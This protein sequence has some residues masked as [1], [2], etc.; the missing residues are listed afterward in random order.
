MVCPEITQRRRP[1]GV[2]YMEND[3]LKHQ[4]VNMYTVMRYALRLTCGQ[5]APV[6]FLLYDKDLLEV[7]T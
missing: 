4:N 6:K 3:H 5:L 1:V 2:G 7:G